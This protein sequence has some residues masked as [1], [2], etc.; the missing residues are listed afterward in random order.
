VDAVSVVVFLVLWGFGFLLLWRI[1]VP[2]RPAGS[3]AATLTVS[4]IIPAR[5]ESSNLDGLLHSLRQQTYAP[6]EIIVIDDESTDSTARIAR[7]GGA[8]VLAGAPLP[9]GWCGKPWACWQG[10]SR[11]RGDLLLFLDA[12]TRLEEDGLARLVAAQSQGGGLVSV[13]PYHRMIHR[14][15][16]LSAFFNL[17]SLVSFGNYG[18]LNRHRTSARA[19]GPCNL[20]TRVDYFATGGHRH[21]AGAIIESLPL[22]QSFL[23]A[24]LCLHSLGGKD[25]VWFRMYREGPSSLMR[26]F[27]KSFAVGAN[28]LPIGRAL[29]ITGWLIAAFEPLRHMIQEALAGN[30][31][32][33]AGWAGCYFLF[34]ASLHRMLIQIGNFR[35]A[36]AFAYP[37]PLLFFLYVFLGSALAARFSG[38]VHWKGRVIGT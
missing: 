38:R 13:Q 33:V 8:Q 23:D 32:A 36:T 5:N 27:G 28:H 29:L 17:I 14:Y 16:Q 2:A 21:G 31:P 34:A 15:E 24:G 25:S 18:I 30:F 4:A 37:I 3:G 1:E 9:K 6:T 26:G 10:A 35:W 19:F 12:D 11:A 20:C 22:G 7:E